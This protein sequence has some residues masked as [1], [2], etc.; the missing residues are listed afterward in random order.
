[1]KHVVA[2]AALLA[3][4]LLASTE[5]IA[6]ERC[7]PDVFEPRRHAAK[8]YVVPRY[9]HIWG[10]LG[11]RSL[12]TL[13]RVGEGPAPGSDEGLIL[14][15]GGSPLSYQLRFSVATWGQRLVVGSLDPDFET[16]AQIWIDLIRIKGATLAERFGEIDRIFGRPEPAVLDQ[17]QL[18]ASYDH[19]SVRRETRD[20]EGAAPEMRE[21]RRDAAGFLLYEPTDRDLL[22]VAYSIAPF[23]LDGTRLGAEDAEIVVSSEKPHM[24]VYRDM[25]NHGGRVHRESGCRDPSQEQRKRPGEKPPVHRGRGGARDPMFRDP[26]GDAGRVYRLLSGDLPQDEGSSFVKTPGQR[27]RT[28]RRIG[29]R[30]SDMSALRR[31]HAWSP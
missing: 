19:G 8:R 29:T 21:I 13:E 24:T 16:Q 17:A 2:A 30:R 27:V 23:F 11:C 4:S 7:A 20:D 6:E 10:Q 5:A 28:S 22:E 18:S 9:A 14:E 31:H 12:T 25:R 3:R 15:C 1:M 26:L